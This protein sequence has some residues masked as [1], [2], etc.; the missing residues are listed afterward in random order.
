MCFL[1]QSGFEG[2]GRPCERFDDVLGANEARV[3]FAP[4]A[5]Q[6]VR[7]SQT[8]SF[9]RP[10]ARG[11]LENLDDPILRPPARMPF[12]RALARTTALVSSLLVLPQGADARPATAELSDIESWSRFRGPNGAGVADGNA[13]PTRLDPA[14]TLRWRVPVARGF[15]SPVLHGGRVFLTSCEAERLFTLAFDAEA[16]T[17]LWKREA[18]RLRREKLDQRNDPASPSPAVDGEVV[19]VFFPESG[20]FAYDLEGQALWTV[21]LGPY[22]NLY[23]MGA[24]PILVGDTAILACDQSLGSYLLCVDKRTGVERWRVERPEAK[25]GHCT[26]ILRRHSDG[27]RELVLPGSFLLDAY[28]PVTGAKRWFGSGLCFEMK[29][30]PVLY[31]DQVLVAGYGSPMNQPGNQV[32]VDPFEEVVAANDADGDGRIARE[33]MPASRAANW[34]DFVDLDLDGT[35]DARDW[36]YLARALAS[37]N[38]LLSFSE[39]AAGEGEAPLRWSYRRSVPQLPSPLIYRDVLYLLADGGGLV[40]TIDPRNGEELAKE[41]VAD[42]VDAYYASPVAGDGKVYLA[43]ESGFL[44]TLPAGGSLEPLAVVELGEKVY[45]TPALVDGSVYVRSTEALYRFAAGD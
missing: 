2:P 25:S 44:V 13:L 19:V 41:R 4:V 15:S 42:A 12:L 38:G 10:T 34:F 11:T 14:E 18:P 6:L 29:S 21:E 26:P 40:T 22:D 27:S 1:V 35:L 36:D 3:R 28:D 23:G 43:S 30:V 37:Q 7:A 32:Q 33:E 39:P 31:G 20:L 45:A 9:A 17:L 5:T 8:G 24:S 16:G